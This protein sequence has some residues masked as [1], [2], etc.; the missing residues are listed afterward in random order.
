VGAAVAEFWNLPP[1]QWGVFPDV[2]AL[3]DPDAVMMT[4]SVNLQWHP[5][6]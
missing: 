2:L 4:S 6:R 5:W 3:T 1:N